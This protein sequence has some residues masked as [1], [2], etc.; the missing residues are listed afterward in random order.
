[1]AREFWTGKNAAGKIGCVLAIDAVG[2]D[3]RG[4][5]DSRRR[6]PRAKRGK[7]TATLEGAEQALFL[8][9][10]NA[11]GE[12]DGATAHERFADGF[13]LGALMMWDI[14]NGQEQCLVDPS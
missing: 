3:C 13:R 4:D 12:L 8:N 2:D 14:L 7:L 6:S 9:F 10:I 1:M 5:A 11:H